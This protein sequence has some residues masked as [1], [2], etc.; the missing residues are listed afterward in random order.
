MYYIGDWSG[1]ENDKTEN[2][3]CSFGKLS[4]LM[5][6]RNCEDPRTRFDSD[7]HGSSSILPRRLWFDPNLISMFEFCR[8]YVIASLPTHSDSITILR[9][10]GV[11]FGPFNTCFH[12]NRIVFGANSNFS[13]TYFSFGVYIWLRDF[14]IGSPS[15]LLNLPTPCSSNK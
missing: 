7:T 1:I 3:P 15:H 10:F 13:A 11:V 14:R 2:I 4:Q 5:I 6:R 9:G 12:G 8:W